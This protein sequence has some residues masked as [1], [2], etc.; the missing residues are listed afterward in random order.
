MSYIVSHDGDR[1]FL[2]FNVD[3]VTLSGHIEQKEF[4]KY[5][6][7]SSCH[8]SITVFMEIFQ[9][10]G[11]DGELAKESSILRNNVGCFNRVSLSYIE[12]HQFLPMCL[13]EGI[14][15]SWNKN[16]KSSV[17]KEIET[18]FVKIVVKFVSLISDLF[19]P[20]YFEKG[21]QML[22]IGY[23]VNGVNP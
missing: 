4:R 16:T 17:D 13:I 6:P 11:V 9:E 21:I 14:K 15:P 1:Q 19:S 12:F 10:G 2:S 3:L 18:V 23:Q 5:N 22:G 20:C 8:G 7:T